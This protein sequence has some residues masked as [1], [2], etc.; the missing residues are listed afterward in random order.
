VRPAPDPRLSTAERAPASGFT[1]E[2]FASPAGE[3]SYGL[4][5][6]SGYAG[7]PVP[8][9]V[10]LHGGTQTSLDAAAGTRLNELAERDTFLVAYPE[11][12]RSAN[13]MRYWN[14]F[15]PANQRHGSGE[16]SLIAG[17]TRHMMAAY[18]V[19]PDRVFIAGFSAGGAMAAVMAATY[20]DLYAA[21]GLHS[22]LAFAAAHDMRSA[23]TALSRGPE[24][25][26]RGPAGG[27]PLILFQGDRDPIVAAVNAE[28]LVA[29]ALATVAPGATPSAHR[30]RSP[31][32]RD[33]TCTEFRTPSGECPLE[34][35]IVHGAGHAWSGGSPEGSYTDPR[36]PDAS[37]EMVRFFAEHPRQPR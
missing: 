9:V 14:W 15:E 16:P 18:T 4:F 11:Q 26:N 7:R 8:L 3:R 23:N 34:E 32:G 29:D 36:G 25:R 35:W 10:M 19:D 20:P 21:A 22:G 13:R 12:P 24:G 33:F 17:I 37:G 31:G 5:V 1:E 2:R 6:P 28:A 30:G 27:V